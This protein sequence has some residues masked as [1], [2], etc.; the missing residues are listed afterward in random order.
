MTLTGFLIGFIVLM[1][2]SIAFVKIFDSRAIRVL[3]MTRETHRQ[4]IEMEKESQKSRQ[5][6]LEEI[7]NPD[8]VMETIIKMKRGEMV[9]IPLAAFDYI[10]RNLNKFAL[11]NKSGKITIVN[12]EDYFKFKEKALSLMKSDEENTLD[13]EKVMQDIKDREAKK[14]I[15][16][17]KHED[18]TIVKTDHIARITEIIKTNG[19]K[20]IVNHK[21]DTMTSFNLVEEKETKEDHKILKEAGREKDKKIKALEEENKLNK[22]KIKEFT[23]PQKEEEAQNKHIKNKNEENYNGLDI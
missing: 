12:Q 23:E 4:E 13:I 21:T 14:P 17:V 7:Q 10:Y 18:G 22:A 11:I 5:R 9:A 1:G 8:L 3:L 16:I 19:E 15:E 6:M 20:V 2:V